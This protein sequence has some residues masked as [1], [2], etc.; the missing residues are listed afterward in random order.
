MSSSSFHQTAQS[1]Y[2][3]AYRYSSSALR[4]RLCTPTGGP[5]PHLQVALK[6]HKP[7]HSDRNSS[8]S[9]RA[10]RSSARVYS[11][12]GRAILHFSHP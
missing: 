10:E 3:M 8:K 12:V 11:R 9:L 5:S 7:I 4:W 1:R 6:K 2:H